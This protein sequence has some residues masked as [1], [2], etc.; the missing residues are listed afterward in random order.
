MLTSSN[1]WLVNNTPPPLYLNFSISFFNINLE[2]KSK[3][4][5]GSSNNI[6]FGSFIIQPINE[7][8]LSIPWEKFFNFVFKK[9]SSSKIFVK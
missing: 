4:E 1:K 6:N 2:S 5:N 3:P 8:F 9:L 7:A